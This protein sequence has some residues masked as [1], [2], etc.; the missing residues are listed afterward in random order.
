MKNWIIQLKKIETWGH[1]YL[2]PTIVVGYTTKV[3]GYYSI[4]MGWGRWFL[5]ID[6]IPK[7]Y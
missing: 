5:S 6:I 2:I 3:N 7:T 4:E 1:F